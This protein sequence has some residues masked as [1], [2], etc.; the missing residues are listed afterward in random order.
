LGLD[1]SV[2]LAGGEVPHPKKG[3]K[4]CYDEI[5]HANIDVAPNF[6]SLCCDIWSERRGKIALIYV[7]PRGHKKYT[8]NELRILSNKF[9]NVLESLGVEKQDK[10]L[11]LLP[12][13]PE[14]YI[15]ML[16]TWK[17]G[18]VL[19]PV[20]TAFAK[21]PIRY[22]IEETDPKVIVTDF[23][24]QHKIDRDN[25]R[26]VIVVADSEGRGIQRGDLSFWNEMDG[27][28]RKFDP[29]EIS[30]DELIS[31]HYSSGTTGLPKGCMIHRGGLKWLYPWVVY[32]LGL[33]IDDKHLV[34][35]W[36]DPAW[37]FGTYTAGTACWLAGIPLLVYNG[38]FEPEVILK[39]A[40]DFSVTIMAG[41]PTALRLLVSRPDLVE[42]YDLTSL[43][44]FVIA[45]EILDSATLLKARELFK[46]PVLDTYG[47]TEVGMVLGNFAV[48]DDLI[49]K[50][51]ER[52]AS[53]G[54]VIP[55]YKVKVVDENGK[56]V[57]TG[58]IGRLLVGN[59][60][61]FLC[62]GYYKKMENWKGR[63]DD[64]GFFDTG[65]LAYF[66]DDGYFYIVGRSDDLIKTSG[67]RVGPGEIE[68]TLLKHPAVKEVA[69]SGVHDPTRGQIIKAYIVLNPGYRS[70][71]ELA[72]E[73]QNFVRE[74]YS[75]HAYPHEIEFVEAIPT[76]ESGKI[77]RRLLR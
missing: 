25:R 13:I 68:G 54:K 59:I 5:S 67:Y 65:D 4:T 71:P 69:V 41:A 57:K 49:I 17:V 37:S 22:R 32:N 12:R 51:G 36:G 6:A 64:E 31:I 26:V 46:V 16:G 56:P 50:Y 11:T 10:V 35:N 53:V 39:I 38:R 60:E 3:Y 33:G 20:F 45:G 72:R 30:E 8:F 63:F 40:Q 18:A 61:W 52:V 42:K 9:A 21:E 55:G 74:Q 29:V 2:K 34:F 62:S 58:E 75:R 15:T 1:M 73:L 28:S 77:M 47:L 70:S 14:F 27:A 43:S 23:A 66:D 48:F 76:T 19:V 24:N 44:H 7:D